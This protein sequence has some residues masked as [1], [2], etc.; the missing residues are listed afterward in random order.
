MQGQLG[1]QIRLAQ[2]LHDLNVRTQGNINA[3]KILKLI[4]VCVDV[5]LDKKYV[6]MYGD[7]IMKPVGTKERSS[8]SSTALTT[9]NSVEVFPKF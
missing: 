5:F 4:L 6:L 7:H 3:T 8:S 9:Q 1:H 2:D